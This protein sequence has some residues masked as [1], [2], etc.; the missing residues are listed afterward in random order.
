MI[1][2]NFISNNTAQLIETSSAL[3]YNEV[4]YPNNI[5]ILMNTNITMRYI[6]AYI[7]IT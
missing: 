5:Y 4:T 7:Y 3:Y 1:E 2:A 6:C